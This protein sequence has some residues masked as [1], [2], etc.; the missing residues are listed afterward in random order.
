MSM[1]EAVANVLVGFVLALGLQIVMFPALGLDVALSDNLLIGAA[2]TAV[3]ILRS[4]MLRR[5]F[6]A[7][8]VRKS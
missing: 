7:I 3:S 2:F 5:L 4:F 6:E 1:V 8:R